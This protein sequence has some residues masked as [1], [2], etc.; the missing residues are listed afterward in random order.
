MSEI[1]LD[2]ASKEGNFKE[3]KCFITEEFDVNKQNVHVGHPKYMQHI[4]ISPHLLQTFI[5]QLTAHC[6]FHYKRA[7]Y[8]QM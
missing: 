8:S 6:V 2:R 5:F 1:N 3:V 4:R 7:N